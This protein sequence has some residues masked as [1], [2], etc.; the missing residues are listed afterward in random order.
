[1][2]L[3]FQS[4]TPPPPPK[5]RRKIEKEYEECQDIGGG[6]Q[7]GQIGDISELR[8]IMLEELR[9]L[10]EIISPISSSTK[11][12]EKIN[13]LSSREKEK[14]L[15]FLKLG[16]RCP[17]CNSKNHDS[18]LKRFFFSPDPK[19]IALKESIL[20]L[21]SRLNY[22]EKKIILGVPCCN[23]Y[24]IVFNTQQRNI[25]R[26]PLRLNSWRNENRI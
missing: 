20:K 25:F 6:K 1:M 10:R 26:G 14:F 22:L 17:I 19:N 5:E 16:S 7:F 2:S 4:P 24:K 8:D 23:C 9:H 3:E 13:K 18:Y 12:E 21:M 15:K 11:W